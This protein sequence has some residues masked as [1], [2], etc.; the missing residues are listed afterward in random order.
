MTFI[1]PFYYYQ[2]LSKIKFSVT[3]EDKHWTNCGEINITPGT[4]QFFVVS[5]ETF[6]RRTARVYV[7]APGSVI[8][9]SGP[10]IYVTSVLENTAFVPN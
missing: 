9:R 5:E 4:I 2:A 3:S 10:D 8:G 6:Q 1:F 7:C